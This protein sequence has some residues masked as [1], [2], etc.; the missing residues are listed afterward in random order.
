MA[1]IVVRELGDELV[2]EVR[3]DAALRGESLKQWIER[4]VL[5]ALNVGEGRVKPN[6]SGDGRDGVRVRRSVTRGEGAVGEAI[7]GTPVEAGPSDQSGAVDRSAKADRG[8]KRKD[9]RKVLKCGRCD[10]EV[11]EWGDGKW[12]CLEKNCGRVLFANEVKGL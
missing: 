9:E 4:V 5:E 1:D 12:K 2:R 8:R 11:L 6:S 3:A 7:R 10:G